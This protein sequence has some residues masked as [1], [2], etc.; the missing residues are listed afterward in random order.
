M[1]EDIAHVHTC[2]LYGE[3]WDDTC[4]I[5]V[6]WWELEMLYYY[7]THFFKNFCCFIVSVN[8]LNVFL[9]NNLEVFSVPTRILLTSLAV[10]S[11][12]PTSTH[13]TL[14]TCFIM[15]CGILFTL[16]EVSCHMNI[17][18]ILY[19]LSS[20]VKIKYQATKF[21]KYFYSVN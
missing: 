11:A 2:I 18:P 10:C 4:V 17:L 7:Q 20:H 9:I 12:L 8:T 1:Y 14:E 13:Q 6:M 5:M 19:K 3:G 21:L 15:Q 16:A